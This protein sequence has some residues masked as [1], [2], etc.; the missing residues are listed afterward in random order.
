MIA[1]R[2]TFALTPAGF[3]R[4]QTE[5]L[6]WV[7]RG[8]SNDE[9]GAILHISA[10]TVKKHLEHIYRKLGVNSRLAA[11]IKISNGR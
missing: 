9:I 1:K 6:L 7:T 2:S 8:K 11:A 10:A 4:R 3:T 5:V